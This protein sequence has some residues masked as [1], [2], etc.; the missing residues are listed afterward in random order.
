MMSKQLVLQKSALF[1]KISVQCLQKSFLSQHRIFCFQK[2]I[3]VAT[4]GDTFLTLRCQDRFSENILNFDNQTSLWNFFQLKF[5]SI[6]FSNDF[7]KS[8]AKQ[9][10]AKQGLC[11]FKFY[12]TIKNC[13]NNLMKQF[14]FWVFLIFLS[15]IMN[16]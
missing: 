3:F 15:F 16:F 11:V 12:K 6:Y 8:N 13:I 10:N 7:K 4:V 2:I 1:Y 5:S 14:Y 9:N